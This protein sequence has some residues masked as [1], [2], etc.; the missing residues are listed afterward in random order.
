MSEAFEEVVATLLENCGY[1]VKRNVKLRVP[2]ARALG[3][4]N[5]AFELDIVACRHSDPF[6]V[7]IVE[8]KAYG[9]SGGV[10][11]QTFSPPQNHH[12][13][14]RYRLFWSP[15]LRNQITHLLQTNGIIPAA[16]PVYCLA[17][18]ATVAA[19]HPQI[20][21]YLREREMRLLDRAWVSDQLV[22]LGENPVYQ[23]NIVACM[24]NFYHG[25]DND[26][27]L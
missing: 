6:E 18:A 19:S 11:W 12:H 3:F 16:E 10:D 27:Y 25:P 13:R 17:S 1:W 14:H 15:D 2:A 4:G 9:R 5:S 20:S 21:S 22:A 7:L 26:G 23:N 24:S 8:C